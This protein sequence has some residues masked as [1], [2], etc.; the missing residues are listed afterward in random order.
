MLEIENGGR[1][2]LIDM[3][4][5]TGNVRTASRPVNGMGLARIRIQIRSV[6]SGFSKGFF[7]NR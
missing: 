4:L 2:L 5:G 7:Y 1:E 3:E 6:S